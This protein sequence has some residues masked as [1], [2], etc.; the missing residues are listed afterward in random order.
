[1]TESLSVNNDSFDRLWGNDL[2][3]AAHEDIVRSSFML[4]LHHCCRVSIVLVTGIERNRPQ[5]VL[6][7][8]TRSWVGQPGAA[9]QF[10]LGG[11]DARE[12]RICHGAQFRSHP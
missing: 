5:Q 1:M 4:Q 10:N 11:H 2:D 7:L 3:D 8:R 6:N 12:V 9:H